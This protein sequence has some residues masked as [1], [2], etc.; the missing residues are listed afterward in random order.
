MT[1]IKEQAIALLS[2][3]S[4]ADTSFLVRIMENL[5]GNKTEGKVSEGIKLLD[6][7]T[8]IVPSDITLEKAKDDY[9]G[10]KYG[11]SY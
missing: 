8:G 10:E 6:S 11:N 5:G 1:A 9:F 7:I 3:L 4:D 2:R